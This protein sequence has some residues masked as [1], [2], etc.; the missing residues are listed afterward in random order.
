M[1]YKQSR[2]VDLGALAAAPFI[3]LQWRLLLV[4]VLVTLAVTSVVALPLLQALGELLNHS[5]HAREWAR[6]FDGMMFGDV[7]VAIGHDHAALHGAGMVSVL[8]L[9]L[10]S[11][12]LSGMV[13]A[14]GRAGRTLGFA[15]LL[16]GGLVEYGRM[17]RLLLWSLPIYGLAAYLASLA[18]DRADDRADLATLASQA[19]NAS[20]VAMWT[21][22]VLLVVAQ[23]WVESARAAYIAD[24]SLRS[25][26][27]AMARGLR[28]VLRRPVFTLL[29]Y[30]LLTVLG[31][32]VALGLGL[33]RVRTPAVGAQGLLLGFVLSQCVVVALGWMRIARLLA[34]SE[35]ARSLGLGRRAGL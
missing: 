35:V 2:R 21:A 9:A 18:F 25:A 16:Q 11:P 6:Q 1:A 14:S 23:A 20:H 31:L 27:V 34:L 7:A 8:M 32:A 24:P 30:L 19:D 3:A 4:W 12:W 22:G 28:Q 5:V 33:L 17:F 13:V 15:P 10:L 29:V 26:T